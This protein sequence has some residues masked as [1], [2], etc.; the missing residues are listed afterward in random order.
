MKIS[1]SLNK[2]MPFLH[3]FCLKMPFLQFN[4]S[5]RGFIFNTVLT[6]LLAERKPDPVH[7]GSS[8]KVSRLKG[9]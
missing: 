5:H 4:F 2:K 9:R 6:L 1:L 7:I 8:E 3:S